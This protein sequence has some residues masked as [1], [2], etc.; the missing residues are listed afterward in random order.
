[1]FLILKVPKWKFL[2]FLFDEMKASEG[3]MMKVREKLTPS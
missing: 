1:M 3:M 2:Y